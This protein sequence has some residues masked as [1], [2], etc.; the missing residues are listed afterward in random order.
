MALHGKAE[1]CQGI[2]HTNKERV[3]LFQLMNDLNNILS[4]RQ[5]RFVPG[6]PTITAVTE[7]VEHVIDGLE[8]G[9]TVDLW[10]LLQ[11]QPDI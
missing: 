9:K 1:I 8:T 5:H 7:I 10:G 3:V 2:S 11:S 4:K 6:R